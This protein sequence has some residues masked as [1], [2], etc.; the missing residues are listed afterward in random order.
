[1]ASNSLEESL[2]SVCPNCGKEHDAEFSS[3]FDRHMHYVIGS[4][5]HCGYEIAMRHDV[6]GAG[7]FGPDGRT[8][9]VS[10]I[11]KSVHTE[12]MRTK[13]EESGQIR[14]VLQSFSQQRMRIMPSER[15]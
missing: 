15:K 8:V 6:F 12:H 2:E 10:T 7:I 13:L 3:S 5:R 14:D 1:M 9:T 11:F 4:C